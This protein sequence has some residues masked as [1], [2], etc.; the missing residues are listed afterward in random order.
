[1]VMASEGV[2]KNVDT[3]NINVKVDLPEIKAPQV[4]VNV[5]VEIDGKALD[6]RIKKII[7]NDR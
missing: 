6:S 2:I 1:M 7:V 3:S 5:V 4:K